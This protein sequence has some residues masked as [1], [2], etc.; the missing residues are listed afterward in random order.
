MA[1][2][3]PTATFFLFFFWNIKDINQGQSA[4]KKAFTAFVVQVAKISAIIPK[5]WKTEIHKKTSVISAVFDAMVK[6]APTPIINKPVGKIPKVAALTTS[7]R[8]ETY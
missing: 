6:T 8:E 4:R 5:N 1:P 7:L 2:A 3:A